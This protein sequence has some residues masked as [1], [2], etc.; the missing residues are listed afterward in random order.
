ML[1]QND[2]NT[3]IRMIRRG[4]VNIVSQLRTVTFNKLKELKVDRDK[5]KAVTSTPAGSDQVDVMS[6]VNWI[7]GI[8]ADQK[9]AIWQLIAIDAT[10]VDRS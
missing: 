7:N 8:Q 10:A 1:P 6:I 5:S 3:V 4:D 9:R 2:F